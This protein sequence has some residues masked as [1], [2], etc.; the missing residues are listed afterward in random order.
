MCMFACLFYLNPVAAAT[1]RASFNIYKSRYW[2]LEQIDEEYYIYDL[3]FW[4]SYTDM[5]IYIEDGTDNAQDA[6]DSDFPAFVVAD[7]SY[8]SNSN[9]IPMSRRCIEFSELTSIYMNANGA[10]GNTYV[11]NIIDW[12]CELNPL[13]DYTSATTNAGKSLS[14]AS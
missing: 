4:T 13:N 14:T 5:H 1:Q 6:V 12:L 10:T 8:H 11:N 2:I 3:D 7:T 9:A